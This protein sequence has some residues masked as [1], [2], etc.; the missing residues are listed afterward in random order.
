VITGDAF[1]IYTETEREQIVLAI[2]AKGEQ[3]I[4]GEVGREQ[5]ILTEIGK[6]EQ[7]IQ[8]EVGKEQ[9]IL[10]VTGESDIQSMLEAAR[11]Q[12]VLTVLT[13][14]DIATFDDTG[15]EQIILSIQGATDTNVFSELGKTQ[16]ILT[17]IGEVD[18]FFKYFAAL[19][20][21]LEL[22][23]SDGDLIAILENAHDIAY[24]Q[25]INSP[26]TLRFALPADD[27]KGGDI[28]LANEIWIRRY[29]DGTVIRKFRLSQKRDSR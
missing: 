5:I 4:Q 11:L 20:Y 22:H 9:V 26:H 16:I 8:G 2:L 13:S 10:G 27:A 24:A 12:I 17:I 23:N 6:T 3:L 18:T 28:T 19:K 29:K 14:S 15:K 7:L 21:I 25:M 1:K